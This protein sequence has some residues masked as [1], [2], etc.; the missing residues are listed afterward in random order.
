MEMVEM[1]EINQNQPF[2]HFISV[3]SRYF[4]SLIVKAPP[5]FW[6]PWSVAQNHQKPIEN[7]RFWRGG[8]AGRGIDDPQWNVHALRPTA[9]FLRDAKKQWNPYDFRPPRIPSPSTPPP[10]TLR[11]F[12]T[13]VQRRAPEFLPRTGNATGGA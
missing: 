9:P 3:G 12:D 6:R 4:G 11:R 10:G 13:Q 8:R 7:H 2:H 1:S 5:G